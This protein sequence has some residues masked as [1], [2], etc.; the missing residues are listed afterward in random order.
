MAPEATRA[1]KSREISSLHAAA[2]GDNPDLFFKGGALDS[3]AV[4][5]TRRTRDNR[6]VDLAE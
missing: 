4:A 2:V 6:I 1:R 3:Q 5:A